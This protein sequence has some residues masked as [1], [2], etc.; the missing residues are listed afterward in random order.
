MECTKC[1]NEMTTYHSKEI[2][3]CKSCSHIRTKETL[4]NSFKVL[5]LWE[6]KINAMTINEFEKELKR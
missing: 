3:E 1:K 2:F 4:E 6:F 5:R